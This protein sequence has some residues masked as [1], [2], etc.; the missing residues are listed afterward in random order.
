MNIPAANGWQIYRKNSPNRQDAKSAKVLVK[1]YF[2]G[3][4]GVLAV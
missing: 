3:V 2:L 1:K 4:P